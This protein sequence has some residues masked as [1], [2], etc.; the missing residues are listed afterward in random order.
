MEVKCDVIIFCTGYKTEFPFV[1]DSLWKDSAKNKPKLYKNMF[2]PELSH[3]ETLGFI[4]L[5]LPFGPVFPL[6]ELQS[7]WFTALN[8]GKVKLPN[9]EEMLDEMSG[10]GEAKHYYESE[11]NTLEV[12]WQ[13]YQDDLAERIGVKPNL[14]YYFFTDF[15]LWW[16]L[17]FGP[18]V[19]Y[20]YRLKGIRIIST[21]LFN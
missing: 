19:A 14:L 2:S 8:T 9:K 4:G 18:S 21:I 15:K 1:S 17:F 6:F 5:V 7:R 12:E 20:Q 11:R 16:R 10:K 3:P 13:N